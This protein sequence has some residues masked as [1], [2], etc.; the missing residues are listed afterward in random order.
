MCPVT[1]CD[2]ISSHLQ[3][4]ENGVLLSLQ[5]WLDQ[6]KLIYEKQ[7]NSSSQTNVWKK[8]LKQAQNE[9]NHLEKQRD[10]V[11]D[12][13]EKGV[14]TTEVFVERYR[15]IN[16]K[17]GITQ[18]RIVQISSDI[19]REV[20]AEQSRKIIIPMTE[21]VL[22]QYHKAATPA[23]KNKLLKSVIEKVV[24]TKAVNGR[25]HNDP[26]DFELIIYPKIK[27]SSTNC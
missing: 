18:N 26:D 2:N 22:E 5:Q 4:V 14:Y 9:L 15:S 8:A 12:L 27:N 6:Y 24:Y 20:K 23:E 1:S 13:L 10:N 3:Y 16:E 19:A 21:H 25:W 11:Y 7:S 17:I